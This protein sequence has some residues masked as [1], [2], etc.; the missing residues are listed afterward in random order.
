MGSREEGIFHRSEV[1]GIF[2]LLAKTSPRISELPEQPVQVR[3]DG[4]GQEGW[5]HKIVKFTGVDPA[6]KST[7]FLL[8]SL[9]IS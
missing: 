8:K 9:R 1:T 3:E 4:E 2:G 5:L 6:E 7:I